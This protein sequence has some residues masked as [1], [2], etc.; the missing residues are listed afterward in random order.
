MLSLLAEC[1][2][3]SGLRTLNHIFPRGS[4]ATR[5]LRGPRAGIPR[6]VLALGSVT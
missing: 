1:A 4:R 6:G 3:L 5:Q 2:T